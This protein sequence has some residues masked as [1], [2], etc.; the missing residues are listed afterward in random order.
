MKRKLLDTQKPLKINL[1][2]YKISILTHLSEY[3]YDSCLIQLQDQ[4][5]CYYSSP[6]QKN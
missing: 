3:L 4:A 5:A 2:K 1:L 6:P